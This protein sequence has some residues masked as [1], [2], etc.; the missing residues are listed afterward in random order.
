MPIYLPL[1][2]RKAASLRQPKELTN[3]SINLNN[4]FQPDDSSLAYYYFPEY[5]LDSKSID[6]FA[7]FSSFIEKDESHDGHLDNLLKAIKLWE[8]E[9]GEKVKANVITWRGIMTKLLCLPYSKSDD[10]DLNIV[11]YDGQ[12]FIEEDHALHM[13]KRRPV[14]EQGKVMMYSG[15]KFEKVTTLPKPWAACT[16]DEIEDRYK[17]TVNNIEQYCSVVRTGV[18]GIKVILGGEVDCVSDYKPDTGNSLPHYL[19]LKS[20]RTIMNEKHARTFERKLLKSWAQSFLLGVPKIVYGFRDDN[21]RLKS[22]EEYNTESIPALVK[23][24]TVTSPENQWNGMDAISWYSAL[25]DWIVKVVANGEN[26]TVWRFAYTAEKN[27]VELIQL[28][29][30]KSFLSD[31]FLEHRQTSFTSVE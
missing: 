20:T 30:A 5:T 4:D 19:E 22:I 2:A 8:L 27:H 26:G 3:F 24:S 25:L 23:G 12:I 31:E 29:S 9:N 6:L 21:G 28:E 11:Q 15:Y 7:G 17:A 10:I 1:T 16:R 13:S 14:D 18:A